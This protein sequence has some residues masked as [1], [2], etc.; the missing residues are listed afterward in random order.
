MSKI[1]ITV[2]D[3]GPLQAVATIV[4]KLKEKNCV[5]VLASGIAE[6]LIVKDYQ[7]QFLGVHLLLEST[8][9]GKNVFTEKNKEGVPFFHT[10]FKSQIEEGYSLLV[11][12]LEKLLTQIMPD[13]ILRTTPAY[14]YG[15]DEAIID[16][17]ERIGILKCCYCYQESYFVGNDLFKLTNP[18]ATVDDHARN[19]LISKNISSTDV[20]WLNCGRFLSFRH[21]NEARALARAK[22]NLNENNIAI[23]YCTTATGNTKAEISHFKCF[24]SCVTTERI[25]IKFHP[26]TKNEERKKYIECAEIKHF[27]VVDDL[28]FEECISFADFIV[29]SA[30]MINIDCI[31]Y[32]I[33]SK[34]SSFQTIS[35][36]TKGEKTEEVIKSVFQGNSNDFLPCAGS[37]LTCENNYDILNNQTDKLCTELYNQAEK[38]FLLDEKKIYKNFCVYMD[39]EK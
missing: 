37:V 18:V 5:F 36:F 21:Y 28:A 32:Q 10:T 13:K 23:L 1:L 6:K 22:L 29:S 20:G 24:L 17:A 27:S 30:S 25:Y 31:L 35:V 7:E 34:V 19:F 38:Y 11:R 3:P 26:R 15:I 16:A 12:S 2:R 39:I 14:G 8:V 33:F 4:N 9:L